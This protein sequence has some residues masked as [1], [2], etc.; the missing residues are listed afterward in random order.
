MTCLLL[1]NRRMRARFYKIIKFQGPRTP[2]KI[3]QIWR[4]IF[5]K[6]ILTG[7]GDCGIAVFVI[8]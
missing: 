7:E 1:K 3:Q 2:P 6:F 5:L 4:A 8:V